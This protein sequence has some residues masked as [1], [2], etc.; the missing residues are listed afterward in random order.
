MKYIIRL[1]CLNRPAVSDSGDTVWRVLGL[2]LGS[3]HRCRAVWWGATLFAIYVYKQTGVRIMNGRVCG[4]ASKGV[5]TCVKNAGCSLVDY[6][7]CKPELMRFFTRF[8]VQEPNIM[9]GH[10]AISFS[11]VCNKANINLEHVQ[12]KCN[13]SRNEYKYFGMQIEPL[14]IYMH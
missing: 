13:Y 3:A 2:V 9:S 6:V 7:K 10:C 11:I 12:K 5:F 14:H 4:D 1:N 8:V